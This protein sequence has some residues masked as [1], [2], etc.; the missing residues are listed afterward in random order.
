VRQYETEMQQSTRKQVPITTQRKY[1]VVVPQIESQ[2]QFVT[3][4]EQTDKSKYC[5]QNRVFSVM[6]G[7][8]L[9]A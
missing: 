5:E 2:K 6:R 9:C 1:T 8:E 7:G 3:F 4:I